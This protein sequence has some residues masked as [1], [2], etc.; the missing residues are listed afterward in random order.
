MNN[1]DR[2][3]YYRS[4]AGKWL[5]GT[6]TEEEKKE[7]S[8]WYNLNQDDEVVIESDFAQSDDELSGRILNTINKRLGIEKP[9]SNNYWVKWGAVAA[10][11]IAL[12][13]IAF[14]F[15]N[16]NSSFTNDHLA[17]SQVIQNDISPAVGKAFVELADGSKII[18]ESDVKQQILLQ[19][20][21]QLV[22]GDNE[23]TYSSQN[24]GQ[25]NVT[26]YNT[27]HTPI[28]AQ[29]QVVLSD[30]TKVWMNASSSLR[31]PTVFSGTERIVELTGEAY[32]EVAKNKKMPFRVKTKDASINVLGTHFN[33]M[34]YSDESYLN[35]TLLEGSVELATTSQKIV[36][37]PGQKAVKYN[38]TANINV[39]SADVNSSIA[40]KNGLFVFSGDDIE[41]VMRKISRW[42]DVDIIYKGKMTDKDFSGTISRNNNISEV[43]KMLKL[44]GLVNFQVKD[45]TITVTR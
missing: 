38:D 18:L 24:S 4:L 28:G 6:I 13:S 34:A 15:V 5:D 35:T 2:E 12:V 37:K 23:L 33:V 8:Q 40:W 29:F 17:N 7:F 43:L 44:T 21:S 45:K 10:V 39:S 16:Y 3:E 20:S 19:G 1:L 41:S 9:E 42:Y 26:S 32:F 30:G 25:Q 27:L 31:Y 36:L 22:V 11:L 14:Y